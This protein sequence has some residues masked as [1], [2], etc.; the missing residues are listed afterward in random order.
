[1][2]A[3]FV[4]RSTARIRSATPRRVRLAGGKTVRPMTLRQ[5]AAFCEVL[6]Y[7]AG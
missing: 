3:P 6:L 1:M 4:D 2:P 7:V 5:G